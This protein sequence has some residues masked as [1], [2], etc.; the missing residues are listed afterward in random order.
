MRMMTAVSRL[1]GAV[2]A[3]TFLLAG[4]SAAPSNAGERWDAFVEDL[5]PIPRVSIPDISMPRVYVPDIRFRW[6]PYGEPVAVRSPAVGPSDPLADLPPE[7]GVLSPADI[8]LALR[9]NGFS[10]MGQVSR[11]GRVYT[12]A[13]L[14]RRGDDGLAVVDAR[15]GAIIRFIPGFAAN[16]RLDAK[17]AELYGSPGV[18]LA[19]PDLSRARKPKSSTAARETAQKLAAHTPDALSPAARHVPPKPEAV[20]PVAEVQQPV[21]SQSNPADAHAEMKPESSA[22]TKPP[23]LKLWPTMAMPDVQ[24]F[25]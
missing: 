15:S 6:R 7:G 20:K 8:A 2:F 18:P 10:M 17:L 5:P 14:D 12:A 11:R 16:A 23:E 4:F 1:G 13:V 21:A 24:T 3:T 19:G 9:A 22:P 25:E